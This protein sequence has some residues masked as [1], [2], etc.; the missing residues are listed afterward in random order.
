MSTLVFV[1]PESSTQADGAQSS[2]VPVPLPKDPCEAIRQAYLD[3]TNT[4]SKPFEDPNDTRT[5]ES[6]LVIAPPIPLSESTL[7]VLV[8]I[9]HKT[10]RMAVR[11]PHAMSLGLST[12]M[13]EVAAMSEFALCKRFQTSYESSPCVSP[14]DLPSRKRYRGTS[15]IVEDSEEDDDE[16]DEEEI[17]ES[18]DSYSVSEDT[19]DE[20]PTAKDEDPAV[21]DED[22]TARVEGPGMDDE[23]YGLDYESHGRD[24]EIH[25][26]DDGGHSIESDRLGLEEEEEAVPRGQ[27][28]TALVVGTTVSAPLVLGYGALRRR[29]LALEEGD[30]YTTFEV[31]QG[32]GSAPESERPERVSTFRRPTLTTWTDLEDGMIYIDIPDYPPPAPPVQTPPSPESSSQDAGGLIR[33]HAVQLEG[34]SHALFQRYDRDMGELFTRSRAVKEEIFYQRYRFRSLKYKQE[35]VAVTFGAIWRPLLAF[36][37]WAGQTDAQRAALWHAINDV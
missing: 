25:G 26:I 5:P 8:P 37:A 15:E 14:L 4:E 16:E 30:V 2:R 1:D 29:E 7:P 28:Q 22:L 13:A 9:L 17:Y 35:S 23:G 10:A 12:S 6:P 24:D 11:V 19:E 31:G 21:E 3:R 36:E 33:D 20:G 18:M 32:F 34:L 27:Q